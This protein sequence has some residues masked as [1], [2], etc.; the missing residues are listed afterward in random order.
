[1]PC[2]WARRR[3]SGE[4]RSMELGRVSVAVAGEAYATLACD[5]P[6]KLGVGMPPLG[7]GTDAADGP[8]DGAPPADAPTG[9]AVG[10][11]GAAV[12][13]V[14]VVPLVAPLLPT[15]SISAISVPT[16]TVAS[17]GTRMRTTLPVTG[18]GYSAVTLSVMISTSASSFLTVSPTCLS[19]R[20][21]VPSE[22]D[23]P[24]RG[25]VIFVGIPTLLT[26]ARHCAAT[27]T[28]GCR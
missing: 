3:A 22:T 15:S 24:S 19:Q 28:R 12:A 1:M 5:P 26:C 9:V 11:L 23:S 27:R 16:G 14:E 2:S 25:M 4:T 17:S 20:P 21:T 6:L 13:P 18:E 8:P 7:E 10:A